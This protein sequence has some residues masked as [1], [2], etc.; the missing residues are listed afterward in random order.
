MVLTTYL[1]IQG[2]VMRQEEGASYKLDVFFNPEASM[3]DVTDAEWKDLGRRL[4][5]VVLNFVIL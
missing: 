1:N 3:G 2:H 5:L 4:E